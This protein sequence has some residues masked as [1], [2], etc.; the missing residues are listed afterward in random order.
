[1]RLQRAECRRGRPLSPQDVDE[2]V[3]EE[4]SIVDEE[5]GEHLSLMRASQRQQSIAATDRQRPEDLEGQRRRG[6][7]A[8]SYASGPQASLK[9]ARRTT[10]ATDQEKGGSHGN[11]HHQL[12]TRWHDQPGLRAAL[13]AGRPRVRRGGGTAFEGLARRSRYQHLRRR[14]H[15][16]IRGRCRRGSSLPSWSPMSA[17]IPTSSISTM[18]R[19]QVL[20]EPTRVTHG[21]VGAAG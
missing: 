4:R 17:P 15:V 11:R 18:R 14:L 5:S 1:M 13:R 3:G 21:L 9:R 7:H 2:L 6:A 12:R 8:E 16:R 19:F 10:V 20:D